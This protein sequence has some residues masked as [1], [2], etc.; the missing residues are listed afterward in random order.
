M[1]K[2]AVPLALLIATLTLAGCQSKKSVSETRQQEITRLNNQW[3]SLV[4]VSMTDCPANPKTLEEPKTPKC[5]AED[6][7]AH[8]I[9]Q[10]LVQLTAQQAAE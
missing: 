4:A 3:N 10:K 2:P 6:K 9:E 7:K 1:R 8:E 5:L